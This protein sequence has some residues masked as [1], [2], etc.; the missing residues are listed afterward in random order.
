MLA[1]N[2]LDKFYSVTSNN[3]FSGGYNECILE[4]NP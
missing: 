3:I 2:G 4:K 1:V